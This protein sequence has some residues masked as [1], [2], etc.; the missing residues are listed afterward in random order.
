MIIQFRRGDAATDPVLAEGEPGYDTTTGD[1]KIGDGATAWSVLPVVGGSGSG[2][3]AAPIEVNGAGIS[4]FDDRIAVDGAGANNFVGPIR[5]VT[6]GVTLQIASGANA[7]IGTAVLVA[8]TVAVA[9]SAL[10]G[11]SLVFVTC[12][13][14]GGVP[15]FLTVANKA[16]G[17]GFDIVSSNPLDT[18]TVAW[19]LIEAP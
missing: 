1:F 13:T 4:V 6:A 7:A 12:Q 2:V 14:P 11:A 18:S 17:V 8:G 10:N 9:T 5:F 3:F 16:N 19:V 15:G